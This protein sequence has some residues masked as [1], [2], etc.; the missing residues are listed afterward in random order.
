MNNWV[1]YLEIGAIIVLIILGILSLGA[2]Y[3]LPKTSNNQK[4]TDP[5]NCYIIFG[6]LY[7]KSMLNFSIGCFFL[8][9]TINQFMDNK[10]SI[11]NF[12]SR[13]EKLSPIDVAGTWKGKSDSDGITL[14][15]TITINSDGTFVEKGAGGL[16]GNGSASLDEINGNVEFIIEESK[17]KNDDY[18]NSVNSIKTFTHGIIFKMNT[19]YG[20]RESK[21]VFIDNETLV[22]V[23]TLFMSDVVLKKQ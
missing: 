5:E 14:A 16:T 12:D 9:F 23:S 21:Y 6:E 20:L 3:N 4:E 18:G 8:V 17:P 2:S 13:S 11:S 10:S 22:P 1:K 7:L 15:E 19:P